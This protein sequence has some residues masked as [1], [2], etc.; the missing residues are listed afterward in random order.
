MFG[1]WGSRLRVEGLGFRVG[2]LEFT[3]WNWFFLV[4]IWGLRLRSGRLGFRVWNL[5]FGVQ[6]VGWG[7]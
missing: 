6:G 2:R 1:G 4:W 3:Y 5:G 7:L